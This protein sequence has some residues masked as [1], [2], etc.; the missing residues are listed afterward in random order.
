[1][2]EPLEV[3]AILWG[4]LIL[5]SVGYVH[6][7]ALLAWAAWARSGEP[8]A[9]DETHLQQIEIPVQRSAC[10]RYHLASASKCDVRQREKRWLNKRFPVEYWQALGAGKSA[11]RIQTSSGPSKGF[12]IPMEAQHLEGHR[13]AWWCVGE[14]AEIEAL[15]QLVTHV[16]R[17]RAVG[18]GE[19]REWR[20]EPCEPWG[21]GFP[22]VD[23]EGRPLRHLPLGDALVTGEHVPRIG[24]LT[25]PYFAKWTEEPIAAPVVQRAM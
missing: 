21:P 1:V 25:Y 11:S 12:R 7:D 8:P 18:E 6:L 19:V 23:V 5:P 3:T 22:V 16:G 14:R 15:L 24:T 10:G 20:V 9:L 13:I 17:R 2:S 4:R